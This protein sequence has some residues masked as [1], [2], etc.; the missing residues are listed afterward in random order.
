[1]NQ[2]LST[3]VVVGELSGKNARLYGLI[4]RGSGRVQTFKSEKNLGFTEP[5]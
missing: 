5:G 2:Y 4:K 1:M 3:A